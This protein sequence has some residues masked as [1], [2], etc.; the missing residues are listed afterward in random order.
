MK[1]AQ[2]LLDAT[3]LIDTKFNVNI[4]EG[5]MY[6]KNLKHFSELKCFSSL[7]E[8]D[9]RGMFSWIISI[10]N[11]IYPSPP[12]LWSGDKRDNFSPRISCNLLCQYDNIIT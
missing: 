12:R 2:C 3:D 6:Y 11:T 8:T 10:K 4:I 1:N 7:M 5:I 9:N